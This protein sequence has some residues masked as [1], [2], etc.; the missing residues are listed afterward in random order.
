MHGVLSGTDR[1]QTWL[2]WLYAVTVGDGCRRG[3]SCGSEAETDARRSDSGSA[4]AGGAVL[5]VLGLAAVPQ[6]ASTPTAS[7]RVGNAI[8]ELAGDLERN[9]RGQRIRHRLDPGHGE[10]GATFRIDLLTG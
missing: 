8:P 1:D 5:A 6:Q 7:S 10:L 2:L 9:D 4:T 3:G